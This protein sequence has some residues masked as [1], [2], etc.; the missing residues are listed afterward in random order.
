[1]FL[2]MGKGGKGSFLIQAA[3]PRLIVK[4]AHVTGGGC[5]IIKTRIKCPCNNNFLKY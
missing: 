2:R 3:F 5:I 4:I 1:M